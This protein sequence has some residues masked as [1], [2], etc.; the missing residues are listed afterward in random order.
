MLIL[1]YFFGKIYSIKIG[2]NSFYRENTRFRQAGKL[3]VCLFACVK[4]KHFNYNR[5]DKGRTNE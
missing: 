5:W 2:S 1:V 3:T 4:I